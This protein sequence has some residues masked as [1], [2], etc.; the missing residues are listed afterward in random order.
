MRF[1]LDIHGVHFVTPAGLGGFITRGAL[2]DLEN[3]GV[4]KWPDQEP[5]FKRRADE[6]RRFAHRLERDGQLKDG[7]AVIGPEHVQT[8]WPALKGTARAC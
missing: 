6:I 3:L 5:A 2:Q 7:I 4:H 8:H 1:E